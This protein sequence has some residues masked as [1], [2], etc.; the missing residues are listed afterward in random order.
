[1][2]VKPPPSD[3]ICPT[4]LY[5][6]NRNVDEENLAR[7][8]D[9]PGQLHTFTAADEFKGAASSDSK[10][11]KAL[12]DL[13]DKKHPTQLKLKVGAQI[14]LL[15][16]KPTL[17]LVN[18]SRGIV[19][20]FEEAVVSGDSYG[21]P[22]GPY[23]NSPIVRF[24]SGITHTVKP[25]S[26]FQG[27]GPHG[28]LARVQVSL[29]TRQPPPVSVDPRPSRPTAFGRCPRS[30]P[31]NHRPAIPTIPTTPTQY[32]LKLAWALTIH[33]AQGMTLSRAELMLSDCWVRPPPTTHHAPPA[34]RHP[35]L[36]ARH[37]PHAARH[38]SPATHNQPRT[39]HYSPVS[40][41]VGM[42][43]GLRGALARDVARWP[44]ATRATTAAGLHQGKRKGQAVLSFELVAAGRQRAHAMARSCIPPLS[45]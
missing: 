13:C 43:A 27:G 33:K 17:G 7:L 20:G 38:S 23:P 45:K 18:G 6:T 11:Q 15:V 44:V 40:L 41:S 12:R 42:R 28:A 26:V 29:G 34:A 25:N 14:V 31:T 39:N 22:D 19:V 9:L 10:S 36:A 21:V 16:N 1:M 35:P 30:P 32:P 8:G 24:D 3:G 2:R 37:P 4:K 5:S